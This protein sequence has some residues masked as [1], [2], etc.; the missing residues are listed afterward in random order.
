MNGGKNTDITYRYIAYYRY[1]NIYIYN[2]LAQSHF[3]LPIVREHEGRFITIPIIQN[4]AEIWMDDIAYPHILN[5]YFCWLWK[6]TKCSCLG[7]GKVIRDWP[8]VSL[9]SLTLLNW[10]RLCNH[11]TWGDYDSTRETN[12][13]WRQ[14]TDMEQLHTC[15]LYFNQY[16]RLVWLGW[17]N[18]IREVLFGHYSL[19][20]LGFRLLRFRLKEPM[21]DR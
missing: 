12:L 1:T 19:W 17:D 4:I 13:W 14:H 5:K 11:D 18:L 10:I 2:S 3:S 21:V 16:L 8:S 20:L 7:V 15:V 9:L 6:T